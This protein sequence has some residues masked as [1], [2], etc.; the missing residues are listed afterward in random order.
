[1]PEGPEQTDE[2][3]QGHQDPHQRTYLSPCLGIKAYYN[4]ILK[5]EKFPRNDIV[6]PHPG[7]NQKEEEVG[8]PKRCRD[9]ASRLGFV[10]WPL[11]FHCRGLCAIQDGTMAHQ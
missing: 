9:C 5:L 3:K 11:Y 7:K 10:P 8:L 2:Q 1:M 6:I 4:T